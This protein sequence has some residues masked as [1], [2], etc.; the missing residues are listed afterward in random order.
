MP[1]CS[2]SILLKQYSYGFLNRHSGLLNKYSLE[3]GEVAE[4][5]N[6]DSLSESER[7]KL[8]EEHELAKFSEDHYLA[9]LMEN[10]EVG[11][12]LQFTLDKASLQQL[13]EQNK[14][15]MKDLGNRE[16]LFDNKTSVKRVYLGMVDILHAYCYDWRVTEGTHCCESPWN[17]SRLSGTLSWFDVRTEF[18]FAP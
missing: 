17:I 5:Q 15:T 11:R 14:E 7:R 2:S 9:D 6:P 18:K 13:T 16:F 4:I 12:A 10:E 8:R 1:S 3:L